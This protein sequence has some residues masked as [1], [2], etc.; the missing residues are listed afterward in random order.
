M[1][2]RTAK[3]PTGAQGRIALGGKTLPKKLAFGHFDSYN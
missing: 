1:G 3:L 2:D